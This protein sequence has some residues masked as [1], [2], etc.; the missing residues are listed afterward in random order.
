VADLMT[1]DLLA[2]NERSLAAERVGDAAEA[3]EYVDG[4]PMFRR[5]R[6][7]ALLQQL[8]GAAGELTP[9]AWA[10]WVVYQALRAED[11][12]S[13]ASDRLRLA[14]ADACE[15][16][17]FDLLAAAYDE[18][19]DPVKVVARVMGESW[20]F[21]QLAA[22]D[23]GVLASYLDELAGDELKE[24][25]A[26]ARSWVGTPMGG[27][28]LEGR[29]GPCALAVRDLETDEE[30]ELLDLGSAALG[31][32]E[33]CVIGRLVP[34]GTTPG[35]MF[36]TAPLGVDELTAR[37]VA[38][39]V[40]GSEGD[41]WADAVLS[42]I[43]EGRLDPG[44]L[45]REDYELLTDVLS[46]GLLEFG[47]RPTDLWRVMDQLH[48]GRDEIGR[49]AFRVLRSAAAGELGDDAAPYVAAAVLN[50]HAYAEAQRAILAPGQG[51]QW[52]H[53]AELVPE[54]ARARLRGFADRTEAAA[55]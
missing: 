24:Q 54:P 2:F 14:R 10:R 31:G 12:G 29:S 23:Y 49:A 28:L 41:R 34:S 25:G 47:T 52:R 22:Y 18:G 4:I 26:L 55:R 5:S 46:I 45:L 6:H 20:V 21:H 13:D 16:F 42:A 38:T 53:W 11:E 19:G 51:E 44:D 37:E 40:D 15:T 8:V 35:L 1:P 27:Y 30:L 50:V 43:E 3:L 36:D 7:R 32:P 33:G 39:D 48:R 17:H 9:W